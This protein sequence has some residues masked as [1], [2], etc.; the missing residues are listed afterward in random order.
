MVGLGRIDWSTVFLWLAFIVVQFDVASRTARKKSNLIKR[1]R[2]FLYS[3]TSVFTWY[4]YQYQ[5][6]R[7]GWLCWR[8]MTEWSIYNPCWSRSWGNF[9]WIWH[10][11]LWHLRWWLSLCTWRTWQSNRLEFN[12]VIKITNRLFS[13]FLLVDIYKY[14][15]LIDKFRSMSQQLC[16]YSPELSSPHTN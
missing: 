10:L 16:W 5:W 3:L 11:L 7:F 14:L 12:N 13:I 6:C 8:S 15:G 9:D 1:R 2:D 4:R